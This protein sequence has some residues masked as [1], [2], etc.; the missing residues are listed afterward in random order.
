MCTNDYI[1]FFKYAVV[2][3]MLE[4]VQKGTDQI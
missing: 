4:E 3:K 2:L 1:K